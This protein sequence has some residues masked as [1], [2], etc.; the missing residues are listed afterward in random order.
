MTDEHVCHPLLD[1]SGELVAVVRGKA[2]MSPEAR[3]AL[4]DVVEAAKRWHAGRRSGGRRWSGGRG[5][6]GSRSTTR[7]KK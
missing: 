7:S 1:A 6:P 2:G 4:L 3:A 5:W